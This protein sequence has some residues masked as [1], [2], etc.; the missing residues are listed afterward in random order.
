VPYGIV[1]ILLGTSFGVLAEPVMGKVPAIV[2]SVVVFAGAAQFGALAVLSAGGGIAAAVV[3]G[4]LLNARFLPMSVA[5]APWMRGRPGK[6]AAQGQALVDVSWAMSSRGGGRFDP[7][8]MLGATIPQYPGWVG[9]TVL[10]VLL[11]GVIGNPGDFGLD[12][13]FPAFFLSLLVAE[14]QGLR[15]LAAAVLGAALALALIP[16]APAGVP[17]I[18]ASVASLLAL[19][20][21]R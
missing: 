20:R 5:I 12:A 11:G 17:I 10:G 1:A 3:A 14:V 16:A 8:F 15:S 9:G 18:V 21:R 4:L 13:I 19:V 6:R 2:M 7:D